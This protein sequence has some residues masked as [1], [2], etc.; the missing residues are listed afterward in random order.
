[1]LMHIC[2]CLFKPTAYFSSPDSPQS[3]SDYLRAYH[4]YIATLVKGPIAATS[5]TTDARAALA[6][7]LND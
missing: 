6:S 3:Q 1:M 7:L 2:R 5:V 4:N